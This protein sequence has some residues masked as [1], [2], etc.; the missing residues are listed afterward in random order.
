MA[1]NVDI[2]MLAKI[3]RET[4]VEMKAMRCE[5]ADD[6]TFWRSR[7]LNTCGRWRWPRKRRETVNYFSVATNVHSIRSTLRIG[8]AARL[9]AS[10]SSASSTPS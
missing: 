9:A 4:L 2:T 5:L 3:G 1:D 8:S 6:R 10:C 7:R